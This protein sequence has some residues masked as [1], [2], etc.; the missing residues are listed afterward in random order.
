MSHYHATQVRI[1]RYRALL[2]NQPLTIAQ[3]AARA[4][5]DVT[6][7]RTYMHMLH[8]AGEVHISD[9]VVAPKKKPVARYFIGQNEDVPHPAKKPKSRPKPKVTTTLSA[10]RSESEHPLTALLLRWECNQAG[11][12]A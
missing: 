3:F 1:E 12:S 2:K 10:H 9:W 11:A 6:T 4:H 8:E 5:C 7:A